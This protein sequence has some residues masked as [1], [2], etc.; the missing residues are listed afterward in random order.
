MA[1]AA[2]KKA[3]SGKTPPKKSC[4]IIGAGLAGLSAACELRQKNWDVTVVE[5]RTASA[6]VFLPI[7]SAKIP[8][9]IA[10]SAGMGRER[11]HHH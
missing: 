8:N 3:T 9:Y 5:A 2:S 6:D 11:P 7:I 10:S 4:V 1:K